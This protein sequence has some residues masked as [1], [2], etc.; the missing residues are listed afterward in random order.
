LSSPSFSKLIS[1]WW[2]F[3]LLFSLTIT[4]ASFLLV[5]DIPPIYKSTTKIFVSPNNS[6]LANVYDAQYIDR[7]VKTVAVLSTS[8]NVKQDLSKETSID[9]DSISTGLKVK[10][11]PGVQIVEAEYS[12]KDADTAIKLVK[13]FPTVL[14]KYLQ[15]LQKDT[16]DK[17]RIKISIAEQPNGASKDKNNALQILMM[18][19][20]S[21]VFVSY[22]L[23]YVL[24]IID[25][26]L[27]GEN[28]LEQIGI[29]HLG[30]FGVLKNHKNNPAAI[31]QSYN[32]MAVEM[33]RQ[34]RTNI[35][36]L[37]KNKNIKTIVITSA[38]AKEGKTILASNLAIMLSEARKKVVLIDADLRSPSIHKIFGFQPEKDLP[39]Y[40]NGLAKINEIIVKSQ[41]NNL[42]LIGTS[43]KINNS[44]E[45]LDNTPQLKNLINQLAE[46]DYIIFDTPPIKNIADAAILAQKSDGVIIAIEK[47]KTTYN[48][49]LKT[50]NILDKVNASII[51]GVLTKSKENQKMYNYHN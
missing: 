46:A 27:K 1:S 7:A 20:I 43:N 42:W 12:D 3:I 13:V 24:E 39:G 25:K 34:I 44:S 2:L 11:I 48:D 38:N 49:I 36:S 5:K 23:V 4:T 6:A 35:I 28:D 17:D 37:E 21:S 22:L 50:K 40:L 10:N 14:D 18:I 16:G 41:F 9:Y 31:T 8:S 45:I 47:E 32:S 33:L 26:T 15:E 29:V 51:G 19:F 30:D